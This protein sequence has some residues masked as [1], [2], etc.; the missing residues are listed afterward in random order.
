MDRDSQEPRAY[1]QSW[2]PGFL[3]GSMIL[4][5][6][7]SSRRLDGLSLVCLAVCVYC[8]G[9]SVT[10]W[11][12]DSG[13]KAA[14]AARAETDAVA[15]HRSRIAAPTG[16]R[17]MPAV[18]ET[19]TPEPAHVAESAPALAPKN[20]SLRVQKRTKP[21]RTPVRVRAEVAQIPVVLP[22]VEPTPVVSEEEVTTTLALAGASKRIFASVD[23][24]APKP[25]LVVPPPAA[26]VRKS[27][28]AHA[29]P[30]TVV[31]IEALTVDG[32]L[33]SKV[34][35]RGVQRLLP[36]YDRCRESNDSAPQ[37]LKLST[38]IDEAGH[39][40]RVTVEGL[41][42][43]SLRHCLEQATARLVVP[44]PDTGT[45]RAHWVVRF[46]AR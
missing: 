31:A 21:V 6:A 30:A 46:A 5:T 20:T 33:T 7:A 44:A 32:A 10:E 35:N 37:Q 15:L 45:A 12:C 34:V 39:G 11:A 38:T 8:L 18:A 24:V 42:Q 3:T 43:P 26:V 2:P 22:D 13:D 27:E 4:D 36:Q 1:S 16:A 40:R 19:I 14:A 29:S 17:A 41:S 25:I 9:F 23:E 28:A